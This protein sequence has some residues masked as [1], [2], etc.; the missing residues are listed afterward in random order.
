MYFDSRGDSA[1]IAGDLPWKLSERSL[2]C[3]PGDLILLPQV[4]VFLKERAMPIPKSGT[5]ETKENVHAN[6]SVLM[7]IVHMSQQDVADEV[8]VSRPLVSTWVRGK[9]RPDVYQAAA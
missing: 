2:D 5:N 9:N 3:N 6:S 4:S 8:G 7:T 1:P